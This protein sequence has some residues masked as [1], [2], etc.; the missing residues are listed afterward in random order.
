[1]SAHQTSPG[2]PPDPTHSPTLLLSRPPSLAQDIATA[3]K[4]FM[5]I[6]LV[7]QAVVMMIYVK[8]KLV[9]AWALGLLVCIEL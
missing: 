4:V 9:P 1:M 7:T 5:G 6:Y 2:L 8:S 3:Q